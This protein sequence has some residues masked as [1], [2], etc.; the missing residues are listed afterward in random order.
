MMRNLTRAL[1]AGLVLVSFAVGAVTRAEAAEK[2]EFKIAWSIYVG[3]MPWALMQETGILAKKA[4]KYGIKITTEQVGDYIESINQYTSG[5]Y[6]GVAATTMDALSI[7]AAGG[8][9]TTL[10]I[11][12]DFSNGNDGIVLKGKTK[13]SD[14]KGQKVNIVEFSV[15]H[16]MLARALETVGLS[17]KDI[18]IVNTSD[19]DMISAFKT[20]DVTAAV[21]WN[22]AFA[23]LKSEPDAHSVF[24]STQIPGELVDVIM[25]NSETLKGNPNFGKAVVE[26]WFET[27]ALMTSDTDAGKAART[28]MAKAS[29]TDLQGFEAQMKTTKFMATPA[30]AKAFFTDAKM[31]TSFDAV[32]TFLFDKG[33]YPRRLSPPT[34]SVSSTLTDQSSARRTT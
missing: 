20:P 27:L 3:Y 6:D 29:G 1:S 8:V 17:E 15:S 26:A 23:A 19:A 33:L 24:D 18:T 11:P 5:T 34:T 10:L 22:P 16:Y 9:D 28:S 30:E 31:K 14:I 7:P 12:T 32:R 2:K 4:E 21:T 13:L 25:V